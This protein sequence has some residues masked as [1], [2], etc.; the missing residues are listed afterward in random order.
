M[1][2]GVKFA[3]LELLDGERSRLLRVVVRLRVLLIA[4]RP[5]RQPRKRFQIFRVGPALCFVRVQLRFRGAEISVRQLDSHVFDNPSER[6]GAKRGNSQRDEKNT[7][8]K[9]CHVLMMNGFA[10][11]DKSPYF[12]EIKSTTTYRD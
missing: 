12:I 3:R 5:A 9:K 10:R 6:A 2:L 4:Q 1:R 8:P 7:R 11:S